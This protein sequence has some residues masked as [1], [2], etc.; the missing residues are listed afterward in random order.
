MKTYKIQ[1]IRRST[2]VSL[3]WKWRNSPSTLLFSSKSHYSH[4]YILWKINKMRWYT[5]VNLS[6]KRQNANTS[7]SL[8]WKRRNSPLHSYFFTKIVS[9]SLYSHDHILWKINKMRGYTIVNLSW[10]RKKR[11]Y[12]IEFLIWKWPSTLLFFYKNSVEITLLS[13]PYS[14]KNQ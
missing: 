12:T 1:K 4:D 6:W 5:I 7:V 2:I 14:L 8:I 13:W 10:K 9:K 11:R 3:M